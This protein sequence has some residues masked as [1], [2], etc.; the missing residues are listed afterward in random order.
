MSVLT[1][2][3]VPWAGLQEGRGRGFGGDP[4]GRWM[5]LWDLMIEP[6]KSAV[7][8]DL[9]LWELA[10]VLLKKKSVEFGGNDD[11][12][13]RRRRHYGR[14]FKVEEVVEAENAVNIAALFEE[15]MGK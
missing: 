8:N 4:H 1:A 14:R 7:F 3:A 6:G 11:D 2:D 10:E 5:M 13:L 9:P 12:H 15:K